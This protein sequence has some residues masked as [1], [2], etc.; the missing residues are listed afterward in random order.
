MVTVHSHCYHGTFLF[1]FFLAIRECL[2]LPPLFF[3]SPLRA[4]SKVSFAHGSG[5]LLDGETTVELIN[6]SAI[7]EQVYLLS[8]RTVL[9][10][11]GL[12]TILELVR[13]DSKYRLLVTTIPAICGKYPRK[14]IIG[15]A[16]LDIVLE[17]SLQNY[18]IKSHNPCEG[19][20]EDG[21]RAVGREE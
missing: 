13:A 18:L 3:L 10:V 15:P 7:G 21:R 2:V 14:G 1:F 4:L 6:Y 17:V 20:R 11:T 19:L 5:A 16:G 8:G 12:H 9:T